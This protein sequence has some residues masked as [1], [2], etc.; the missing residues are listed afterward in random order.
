MDTCNEHIWPSVAQPTSDTPISVFEGGGDHTHGRP[1]VSVADY[2]HVQTC[3][4]RLK[5][6]RNMNNLLKDSRDR[7]NVDKLKLCSGATQSDDDVANE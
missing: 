4:V 1:S 2:R 3:T 6:M 7:L 5:D